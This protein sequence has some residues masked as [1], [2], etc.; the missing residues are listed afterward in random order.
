VAEVGDDGFDVSLGPVR[1]TAPAGVAAKGTPV[2]VSLPDEPPPPQ[3]GALATHV[4]K[5][6]SIVLGDEQQPE[7]PVSII[8]DLRGTELAASVSQETP[9]IVASWSDQPESFGL[10]RGDWDAVNER[11]TVTTEHFSFT[12]PF[13]A[14]IKN[15]I[16][17]TIA[18]FLDMKY[19]KPTCAFA[20]LTTGNTTV[21]IAHDGPDPIWPCIS[22]D[23][24][25]DLSVELYSNSN[26]AWS[27]VSNPSAAGTITG[28]WKDLGPGL[29][30]L[31][32]GIFEVLG[33][34]RS[35][36]M[37]GGSVRIP[38][39]SE[40]RSIQIV[41]KQS[42]VLYDVIIVLQALIAV[43]NVIPVKK[44]ADVVKKAV[45]E[46]FTVFDCFTEV[47]NTFYQEESYDIARSA[48]NS[49][50]GCVPELVEEA[51]KTAP[52]LLAETIMS[53]GA[54]MATAASAIWGSIEG[55]I[56][57]WSGT[58]SAIYTITAD[59]PQAATDEPTGSAVGPSLDQP[60]IVA[61]RL[62]K[63]GYVYNP[64]A[65][66][67]GIVYVGHTG[68]LRAVDAATGQVQWAN[69]IPY[70]EHST[71]IFVDD[72]VFTTSRQRSGSILQAFDRQSGAE[73]WRYGGDG[74]FV[75]DPVAED[76]VI[77][78]SQNETFLAL[79]AATGK[80]R[81]RSQYTIVS[82]RAGA[83]GV[84]LAIDYT[85]QNYRF[86]DAF[87]IA[88]RSV[89]WRSSTLDDIST[90]TV[91]GNTVYVGSV[92]G[93]FHA[94][95]IKTGTERWSYSTGERIRSAATV[96]NGLVF[97]DLLSGFVALDIKTGAERWRF[98]PGAD[99]VFSSQAVSAQ[100]VYVGSHDW[101]YALDIKTG[102]EY[103]RFE[104]GG[105]MTGGPAIAVGDGI[106]CNV[107]DSTS[108][109]AMRNLGPMTIIQDAV[110]RGA[111]S[112]TGG[113]RGRASAGDSAIYR[114]STDATWIE[115]TVDTVTGWIPLDAIDPTTLPPDG[116]IEYVYVP[117]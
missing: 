116:E 99:R 66:A 115:V 113:E 83:A 6:V 37:P 1:I 72:L 14:D 41:V 60:I 85:A 38:F 15:Y 101:L 20:P 31:Y 24:N 27:V 97:V 62:E 79:D 78:V 30:T 25:G 100:V 109:I 112:E 50:L 10:I 107:Y 102:Q 74:I 35:A 23:K 54:L 16:A 40:T 44:E 42:P 94:L 21:S 105:N 13:I 88:S 95:D 57:E 86:L 58:A 76:G 46:T 64:P 71:P 84:I 111:P 43:I 52:W 51:A 17:D 7:Q 75:S 70:E 104:T 98:S 55:I 47:I 19:P 68:G 48:L 59:L 2:V 8:F 45:L 53:L 89:K 32:Q 49:L 36:I 4:R 28:G 92:A 9:L 5:P 18:G 87:D 103:W 114:G 56:R 33:Q 39:D 73:R 77:Y 69:D 61:W 26:M 22:T 63:I 110:I 81:W 106:V 108:F 12:I 29:A 3:I 80:E 67:D 34:N 82:P 117:D 90:L 96:A 93:D 11:L 91:S 65:I